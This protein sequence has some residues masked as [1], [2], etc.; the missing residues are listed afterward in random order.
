FKSSALLGDQLV[1]E[2]YVEKLEG[3]FSFRRVIVR[4]KN[5][6]KTHMKALT[7]WC[8][9]SYETK[10]ICRIPQEFN[11]LMIEG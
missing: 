2:T 4:G 7:K 9:L 8:M 5:N 3:V 11:A 10:R 1:I 6:G